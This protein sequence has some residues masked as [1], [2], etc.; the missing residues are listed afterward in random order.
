MIG[1]D[2]IAI[3]R[4]DSFINKWGIKGLE[5]FL[6]ASEIELCKKVSNSLKSNLLESKSL[7]SS[8]LLDSKNTLKPNKNTNK[9]ESI[10]SKNALSKNFNTSRIAG[11]WAAKEALSKALG[12]GI[13]KNLGFL[14]M[15]ISK[16]S[17]GASHI[18]LSTKA[19][20]HFKVNRISLSISHD[21]GFA[22]AAVIVC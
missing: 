18:K 15:C 19:N 16:D 21:G 20:N 8:N 6:H 1:I 12:C 13:S 14:D 10:D 4:I 7:E 11:F 2:I 9:L 3:S 5:K 17:S 22:I